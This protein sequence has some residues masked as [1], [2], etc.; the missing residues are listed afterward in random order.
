MR[1]RVGYI[2][3]ALSLYDAHFLQ[4]RVLEIP[5][6]IQTW[7]NIMTRID[8][9]NIYQVTLQLLFNIHVCKQFLSHSNKFIL[10]N[11]VQRGN[12]AFNQRKSATFVT[13]VRQHSA[14]TSQFFTT[15]INREHALKW[16]LILRHIFYKILSFMSKKKSVHCSIS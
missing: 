9:M 5:F 14:C 7:C 11:S 2:E 10:M 4:S 6:Y 8:D 1:Q 3:D 15:M 16:H 13:V 12:I